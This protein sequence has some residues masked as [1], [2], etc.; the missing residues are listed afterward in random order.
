MK[1]VLRIL[2]ILCIALI[3]YGY[4][5][6][7]NDLESGEKFIGAGVLVLAFIL[8]PLFIFHRYKDKDL[9]NYSIKDFAK[10]L[11]DKDKS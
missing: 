10:K 5:A 8:M 3:A 2:L 7:T 6:K 4:Y 9:K 11:E 1:I